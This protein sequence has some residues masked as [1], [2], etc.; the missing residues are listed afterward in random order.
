MSSEIFPGVPNPLHDS[1]SDHRAVEDETP[2]PSELAKEDVLPATV[3]WVKRLFRVHRETCPATR[4]LRR[5]SML[6][7]FLQGALFVLGLVGYFAGRAM[8]N[9]AVSKAT[10]SSLR[11][12][13]RAAVREELKDL[14]IIHGALPAGTP[15]T[16]VAVTP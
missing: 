16:R 5:W 7:V 10:Q 9:E 11:E 12:V 2:L 13:V 14:G 8:L 6:V 15:T 1:G 4:R 3:G